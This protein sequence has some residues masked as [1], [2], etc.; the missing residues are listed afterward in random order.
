MK[1]RQVGE[2][3]AMRARQSITRRSKALVD[4]IGISLNDTPTYTVCPA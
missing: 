2:M 3:I 1:A 4:V